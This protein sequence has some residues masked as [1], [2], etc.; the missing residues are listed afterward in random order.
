MALGHRSV[1]VKLSYTQNNSNYRKTASEG[2]PMSWHRWMLRMLETV[3][4]P[5]TWSMTDIFS[6]GC[7]YH[8]N[9]D[10]EIPAQFLPLR[11]SADRTFLILS[12]QSVTVQSATK[13][14]GERPITDETGSKTPQRPTERLI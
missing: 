11:D 1:M 6:N 12:C 2:I 5:A 8:P 4:T 10:G 3:T 13:Y 7:S 14:C 9:A